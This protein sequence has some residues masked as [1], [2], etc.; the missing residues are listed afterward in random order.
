MDENG[1]VPQVSCDKSLGSKGVAMVKLITGMGA[2]DDH[3][4]V[5]VNM[6]R[7][8]DIGEKLGYNMEGCIDTRA[9]LVRSM[10]DMTVHP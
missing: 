2:S 8:I 10:G 6:N 3:N 5:L 1:E 9:K 4:E 7:F